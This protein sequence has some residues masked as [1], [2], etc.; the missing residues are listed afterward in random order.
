MSE[1]KRTKTESRSP[2]LY[3]RDVTTTAR[4]RGTRGGVDHRSSTRRSRLHLGKC[5]LRLD[6]ALFTEANGSTAHYA[7]TVREPSSASVP[8]VGLCAQYFM[9]VGSRGRHG[10]EYSLHGGT[11]RLRRVGAVVWI[12]ALAS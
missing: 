12:G 5:P 3:L 7:T 2:R 6:D 8:E 4:R 11:R 9:I 10:L 1:I